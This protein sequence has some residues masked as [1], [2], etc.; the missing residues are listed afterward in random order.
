[1]KQRGHLVFGLSEGFPANGARLAVLSLS[2]KVYRS[3]LCPVIPG[4]KI[5]DFCRFCRDEILALW[6]GKK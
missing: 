6:D 5:G 2:S 3:I 1:V 4:K